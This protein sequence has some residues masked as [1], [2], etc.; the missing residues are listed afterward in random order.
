MRHNAAYWC[1]TKAQTTAAFALPLED[2]DK[3]RPIFVAVLPEELTNQNISTRGFWA[4]PIKRILCRALE[5]YGSIEAVEAAA[6][7]MCACQQDP[8]FADIPKA[9]TLLASRY[10]IFRAAQLEPLSWAQT[11]SAKF[12][13]KLFR[14][15]TDSLQR[16]SS[17]CHRPW[18]DWLLAIV[19]P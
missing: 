1:L 19:K 6:L 17:G 5:L 14:A 9:A 10:N 13:A 18:R 2:M 11:D 16:V 12:L 8:R 15:R 4:Y 3:I 7:E